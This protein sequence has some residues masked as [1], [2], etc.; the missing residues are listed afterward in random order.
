ML[1]RF[2]IAAAVAAAVSLPAL[3]QGRPDTRQM[4]CQQARSLVQQHGA[5][6]MT[7]GQYTYERFVAGHRYCDWPFVATPTWT[8]TADTPQCGLYNCQRGE[9]R[10]RR[11]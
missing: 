5:V 6:V 2:A 9:D 4:S 11:D 1:T 7:T 8:R 3:A 10:F